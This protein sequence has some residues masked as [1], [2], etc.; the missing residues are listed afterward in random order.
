M[1][2]FK[3]FDTLVYTPGC[4]T[5]HSKLPKET[6]P[7]K[8]YGLDCLSLKFVVFFLTYRPPPESPLHESGP[9]STP[10]AQR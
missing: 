4:P 8:R 3:N 5:P 10:P 1:I 9:L 6:I 2:H 7:T